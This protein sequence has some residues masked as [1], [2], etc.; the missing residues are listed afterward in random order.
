MVVVKRDVLLCWG[1]KNILRL[2]VRLA[3]VL[4]PLFWFPLVVD[5]W[6]FSKIWFLIG[7]GIVGML[8][9]VV[10]LVLERDKSI[11]TSS[12][13]GWWL[14][15]GLWS[16]VSF[17]RLER[18]VEMRSI[19]TVGGMGMMLGLTMW[20]FLWLQTSDETE[21][22]KQIEW[23]TVPGLIAVV[24]SLVVFL[25]PA[26]RLPINWPQDNPLI[27]ID[28]G[29]SLL[30]SVVVEIV[31]LGFLLMGWTKRLADKLK[32]GSYWLELI[33]AAV[34]TLGLGLDIFRLIRGGWAIIDNNSAWVIAVETFKRSPVWGV[35]LGNFVE[36]FYQYRPAS[37]NLTSFW[38]TVFGGSRYGLLQLWT[39]LG[40]PALIIVGLMMLSLWKKKANTFSFWRLMVFSVVWL[41]TPMTWISWW[42][43]AWLM[44]NELGDRKERPVVFLLG[45]GKINVLPWV[46]G[47]LVVGGG[48][49]GGYWWVRI[50][51]GEVYMRSSLLA[52]SKND[53][54]TTYNDQIRA[55]A[56]NPWVAEYR[57]M[58]SQTNLALAKTVLANKDIS[59]EDKQKAAV[60]VQ[61]SVREGKA[62]IA[63]EGKNPV[64]WN[65][66]AVIYRDLVGIVDGAADW[67][68]QAYVQAG[69]LDVVNPAIKL[70]LGG[71]LYAANRVEEADRVFEQVVTNK[72]DYANGWYNWAYTA[73]MMGRLADAVSR[74]GQAVALVPV[75]SGDYEKAS[76]ELLAWRKELD[77]AIK[78][79]QAQ[80][81]PK[82]AE[83]LKT[84]EPLPTTR[85]EEKV[86][87]SGENLEPPVAPSASPTTSASP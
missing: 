74:L 86:N 26:S 15:L 77:E 10:V 48:L 82:P 68:Y 24:V 49:F 5:P 69:A 64:F 25:L 27:G 79:Q 65:N 55:I 39:E 51:M 3:T 44:S 11:I 67:S 70:D 13:F 21:K 9:W 18:G 22:N 28:G 19:M 35:G 7:S 63:L 73:K 46:F 41:M 85:K 61:Q 87:V 20:M 66:L 8:I 42:L 6:G 52:A 12:G 29:F 40:L 62:A 37:Y 43:I 54:T 17:L 32:A 23:L 47:V 83:T 71:L 58:Y 72:P 50:L 14:L 57:R 34:L 56:M 81:Q 76:E 31:F 53:G 45:E 80:Q 75:D 4:L 2:Y 1:M 33:V 30:G 84:P 60:L 78:K 16:L 36:A 59:E 38:A